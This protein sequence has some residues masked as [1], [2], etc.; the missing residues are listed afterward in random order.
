MVRPRAA[1]VAPARSAQP[2]L[3]VHDGGDLRAAAHPHR[4]RSRGG[5][6]RPAVAAGMGEGVRGRAWALRGPRATAAKRPR[7]GERERPVSRSVV[8]VGGGLAGITAALTCADAGADVV[9]L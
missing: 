5:H 9:L 8:V 3:R 4:A 6:A 7:G 2:R 1:T